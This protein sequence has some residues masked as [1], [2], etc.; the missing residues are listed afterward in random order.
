MDGSEQVER[1]ETDGSGVGEYSDSLAVVLAKDGSQFG[2]YPSQ[3]LPVALAFR[4]HMVNVSVDESVIVAG[5]L[6]FR[7]VKG[8]AFEDADAAFA[9]GFG[10]VNRQ[11]QK[12]CQWLGGLNGT[13]QIARVN[14]VNPFL[15]KNLSRLFGLLS[16]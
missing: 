2:G 11:I 6:F 7:F 10:C 12:L 13:Q 9:K 16:A 14:S 1:D 3:Q 4:D 8:E 5:K 15:C